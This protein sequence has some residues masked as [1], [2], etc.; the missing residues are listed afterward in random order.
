MLPW[1]D[2]TI[3]WPLLPHVELFDHYEHLLT[4]GYSYMASCDPPPC[5][6]IDYIY[7]YIYRIWSCDQLYTHHY[8]SAQGQHLENVALTNME[9]HQILYCQAEVDHLLI[10]QILLLQIIPTNTSIIIRYS[11]ILQSI[12]PHHICCWCYK[13]VVMT[14]VGRLCRVAMN[15]S[16]WAIGQTYLQ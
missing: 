13:Q 16:R 15:E 2:P 9:Q 1:S 8:W 3:D 12:A 11:T 10:N 6:L 4:L 5:Y 14:T 7:I